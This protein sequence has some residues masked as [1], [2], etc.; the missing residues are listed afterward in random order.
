MPRHYKHMPGKR[1]YIGYTN[2]QLQNALRDMSNGT[3]TQRQ[4]AVYYGIPRSTLRSKIKGRHSKSAGGQTVLSTEEEEMFVN[5]CLKMSQFGFPVDTFD[6][7]LIV[8]MYLERQGR[9]VVKFRNNF[10]GF[11]WSLSFMKRHRELTVRFAS[12]IK[13]KRAGVGDK[14]INEYFDH[15]SSELE[16]VPPGNIWNYDE[17]NLTDDPGKKRVITKRGIKYPERVINSTK[18]ATSLMFCGSASGEVLPP[19]V[20]YKAEAIWSTW[21]EHGPVGARYNRSKSGWFDTVCFEDWFMCLLLPR[22]KKLD[23]KKVVIGDNLSSHINVAVLEA[24]NKY[25]IAFIAL[26]ANSSHLTQPLDVAYFRPMKTVW[27][28]ILREWKES[29]RGRKLPS[30]PKDQFPQL[31]KKL[32]RKMEDKDAENLKSGFRKT[33]IYPLDRKQVLGRIPGSSSDPAEAVSASFIEHLVQM[34][35]DDEDAPRRKRCKVS[36]TPGKSVTSDDVCDLLESDKNKKST[37]KAVKTSA[38]STNT[39]T[40]TGIDNADNPGPSASATTCSGTGTSTGTCTGSSVDVTNQQTGD[41]HILAQIR[42]DEN[43]ADVEPEDGSDS[44]NSFC[45]DSSVSSVVSENGQDI[46][47]NDIPDASA[48]ASKNFAGVKVGKFVVVKYDEN[49]YP[50]VVTL[51]KKKGAEVCVM[52]PSGTTGNWKWPKHEDKLFYYSRDIMTAI[53]DPVPVGKRGIFSV[54]EMTKFV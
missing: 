21:T 11:D 42:E 13:R 36:V 54:A 15:L 52:V 41:A 4:A 9:K 17:T 3:L 22:L 6:L 18:T 51:V 32:V 43:A 14:T 10:P 5:Y 7:R 47:S 2:S 23:G 33:G 34:R 35:G 49:F 1:T 19:Y 53:T 12:N 16:G 29:G 44:E 45:S 27:R 20:V 30:L 28:C 8:K 40:A 24:C 39:G 26:P 31:L 50:G 37:K 48:S 25:N 46:P 38:P